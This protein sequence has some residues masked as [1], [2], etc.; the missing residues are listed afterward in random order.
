M[1]IPEI[2]AEIERLDKQATK[3]PWFSVEIAEDY[4]IHTGP[5]Y[6]DAC[7]L[8]NNS[9]SDYAIGPAAK[10]NGAFIAQ[11]RTLL[12][13]CA[14]LLKAMLSELSA[15]SDLAIPST[16]V[17]ERVTDMLSAIIADATREA[18]DGH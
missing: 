18:S 16:R 17:H 13:L 9:D 14:M 7:L 11:S 12:P 6:D 15:C 2:I 5:R 8:E 4:H 1:T 3:G 10:D